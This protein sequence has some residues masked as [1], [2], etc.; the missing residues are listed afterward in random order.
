MS[1]SQ[2]RQLDRYSNNLIYS[3]KLRSMSDSLFL[4]ELA[5]F[6]LALSTN[7]MEKCLYRSRASRINPKS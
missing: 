4:K 2:T 3:L 7:L 1:D 5:L 6:N